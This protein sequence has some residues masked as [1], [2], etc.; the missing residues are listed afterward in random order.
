MTLDPKFAKTG[1][2]VEVTNIG[3]TISGKNWPW[4]RSC[5][6]WC[7]PLLAKTGLGLEVAKN[8]CKPLLAKTNTSK[9]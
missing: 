8:R 7:K 9:T 6:N 2:G 1:L 5:Q 4:P 3:E